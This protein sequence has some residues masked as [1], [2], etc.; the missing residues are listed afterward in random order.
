MSSQMKPT[1]RFDQQS[2][3]I[4]TST[5]LEAVEQLLTQ[6]NTDQLVRALHD[7]TLWININE[8]SNSTVNP[9]AFKI[10][11]PARNRST[12]DESRGHWLLADF[13]G[14]SLDFILEDEVEGIS[15]RAAFF[16]FAIDRLIIDRAHAVSELVSWTQQDIEKS[17]GFL[18]RFQNGNRPGD[19]WTSNAP[20]G[21]R[22][23]LAE[24][25]VVE[26]S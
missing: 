22:T 1:Y 21:P 10:L 14:M 12:F 4:S 5:I 23:W 19:Y 25:D 13:E 7:G 8:L 6:T 3:T 26:C 11:G 16:N 18:E 15:D 9:A 24:F 20:M 17:L 2:A